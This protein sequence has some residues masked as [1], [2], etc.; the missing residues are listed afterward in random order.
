[1]QVKN[2][3]LLLPLFFLFC[4]GTVAY[5]LELDLKSFFLSFLLT[6]SFS[7]ISVWRSWMMKQTVTR[8]CYVS[9]L[10]LL[11]G[12]L[13]FESTEDKNASR[14]T[15]KEEV[16]VK[17]QIREIK[18]LPGNSLRLTVLLTGKKQ[19]N[20]I[21]PMHEI[22][23]LT[24]SEVNRKWEV[25]DQFWA[26]IEVQRITNNGNPGEFDAR[27]YY[28]SKHIYFRSWCWEDALE[29]V[30]NKPTW[31]G[32]FQQLKLDLGKA[33][34][35]H[36]DGTFL[37]I[38][39]ALLLGDKADLDQ[40][41]MDDFSKTGSMHVLAVSGMH[42]GIIL[43]MV[44]WSLQYL[45]K[46]LKRRTA[47]LLAFGFVW[48]YGFL[49]GASPAVMRSVLMFSLM[50]LAELI[51]RKQ[52]GMNGLLVAGL[53]LFVLDP[54]VILDIGFQLTFAAMF[55]IFLVYPKIKNW[56]S[57]TK[58]WLNWCWEGTAVGL[59]AT[60]T[61]TPITLYWFHQFPNYFLLSNIGVMLFGTAVL[62]LGV[63]FVL[64]MKVPFVNKIVAVLYSFSIIG[65]VVWVNWVAQLDGSV[66]TG[67]VFPIW[68]LI[69]AF[70]AILLPIVL[71]RFRWQFSVGV[72]LVLFTVS[73]FQR[74][75][76]IKTSGWCV[77]N[78]NQ[79]IF[80]FYENGKV[81]GVYQPKWGHADKVPMEL[82]A[83]A[84]AKGLQLRTVSLN[85]N[86]KI[87]FGKHVLTFEI[88][89][90]VIDLQINRKKW[91][92]VNERENLKPGKKLIKSFKF[93]RFEVPNKPLPI[94]EFAWPSSE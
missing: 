86:K 66:S 43:A 14:L 30:G 11:M 3:P 85:R 24:V 83:F 94:L 17:G 81:L 52:S 57:P 44:L 1:M 13:L 61:T 40:E 92:Y 84:R 34:G 75:E 54:M 79:A 70:I 21:Q 71:Q 51:Q 59:A 27:Y 63:L 60:I 87:Q 18:E 89:R 45:S 22:M 8:L 48:F 23:L 62:F 32:F 76:T 93:R 58:K 55:G 2:L 15:D 67:V 12:A 80:C 73:A 68:M 9:I 6:L 65:L 33:M 53:I 78:A 10:F 38:S 36:L 74:I 46:W 42:V 4:G 29:W 72:V 7:L 56:F 25:D 69:L 26:K 49:T 35:E 90:D 16:V 88:N 91:I 77:L 5:N 82:T 47:L 41:T 28:D 31:F 20:R 37:G 39:K 50:V 19:V 64:L